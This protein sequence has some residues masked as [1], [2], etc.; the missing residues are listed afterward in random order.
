MFLAFKEKMDGICEHCGK[1]IVGNPYRI[2]SEAKTITFLDMI[3]CSP[4]Y[5]EAKRLRL[6]TEEIDLRGK[7]TFARTRGSQSSRS[8]N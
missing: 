3:V 8:A 7:Q 2:I 4:C 5:L 1:S 6:R